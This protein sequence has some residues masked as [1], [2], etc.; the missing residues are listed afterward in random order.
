MA[1]SRLGNRGGDLLIHIES[2]QRCLTSGQITAAATPALTN[3][4]NVCGLPLLAANVIALAT[5]EASVV[6]LA[7]WGRAINDLAA[8][9][10]TAAVPPYTI[11]DDF[12]GAVINQN[13]IA[14]ADPAGTSYTLATIVTALEALG[15]KVVAEPVKTTTQTN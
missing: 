10:D 5:E 4:P 7:V 3:I 9:G 13:A 11:I 14:L 12:T 1:E 15:A 6:A 2:E 8:D